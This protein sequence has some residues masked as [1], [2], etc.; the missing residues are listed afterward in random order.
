[1]CSNKRVV[2]C[3]THSGHNQ[4]KDCV[5]SHSLFSSPLPRFLPPS[6]FF[7]SRSLFA[8]AHLRLCWRTGSSAFVDSCA[9]SC[10]QPADTA[11]P[12][13]PPFRS[14]SSYQGPSH[15]LDLWTF[16]NAG[17][18]HLCMLLDAQASPTWR[19]VKLEMIHKGM[20]T[21]SRTPLIAH[22]DCRG[23]NSQAVRYQHES[24]WPKTAIAQSCQMSSRIIPL[25]LAHPE[26]CVWC[27]T[28]STSGTFSNHIFFISLVLAD[29]RCAVVLTWPIVE[30]VLLQENSCS[31]C[32]DV[33]SAKA[34]SPCKC[35]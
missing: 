25:K 32:Q 13:Q 1:M 6:F 12:E 2:L 22:S 23:N 19:L 21:R 20:R 4:K 33:L 15:F 16:N 8:V 7:P 18:R 9:V 11:D 14:P 17:N 10:R 24:P 27:K 28:E 34:P 35:S 3:A 30:N 31:Q 26:V 29:N 5:L